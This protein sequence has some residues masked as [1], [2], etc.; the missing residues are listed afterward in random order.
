MCTGQGGQRPK[1]LWKHKNSSASQ[2]LRERLAVED[3][4]KVLGFTQGH[5][6]T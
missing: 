1:G 3:E 4:V 2:P 5:K 6:A